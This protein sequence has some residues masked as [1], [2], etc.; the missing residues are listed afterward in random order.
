MTTS[1]QQQTSVQVSIF[2]GKNFYFW[3]KE[4]ATEIRVKLGSFSGDEAVYLDSKEVSNK[5]SLGR[6]SKHSFVHNDNQY[7]VEINVTNILLEAVS[8]TL[9][10]NE[11]HYETLKYSLWS[12]R[13]NF[14]KTFLTSFAIGSIAGYAIVAYFLNGE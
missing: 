2:S 10:K 13:K 8:C 14:L 7:E 1:S 9:I 6:I 4:A 5:H 12:H 3:D 11:T